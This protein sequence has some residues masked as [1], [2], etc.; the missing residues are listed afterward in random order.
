M[1]IKRLM[2]DEEMAEFLKLRHNNKNREAAKY[3]ASLDLF[4]KE[5]SDIEKKIFK[6]S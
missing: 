4:Y 6:K 3:I 5:E 2:S 1:K